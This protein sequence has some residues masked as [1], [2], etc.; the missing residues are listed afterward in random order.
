MCKYD[1]EMADKTIVSF[2]RYLRTNIETIHNDE[3]IPFRSALRQL[4]DYVDL[5]QIRFPDKLRFDTDITVDDFLIPPLLL[6]P[7]VENAIRHGINPKKAGGRI[8]LRTFV[9]DSEICIQIQD[10]GV[11]C[12]LEDLENEKST[13]LKN[14]RF[15]LEHMI[16]GRMEI[17]SRIGAGTTVTLWMPRKEE[18]R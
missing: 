17:E 18:D 11:G 15:R 7:I 12:Y 4:L 8:M 6:Q 16:G 10:N 1:P 9:E 14:I 5:E 13:A 3:L 2:A